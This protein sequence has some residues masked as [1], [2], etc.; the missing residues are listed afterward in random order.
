LPY[1]F[2]SF[3]GLSLFAIFYGLDWLATVP[4]T[5]RL[6]AQTFGQENT[7]IMYG[8]LGAAHQA[9]GALAAF[10]AGLLRMDL[11]TYLQA[12]MLSG[13]MCLIA[14]LMVM[15]IGFNQKEPR[16]EAITFVSSA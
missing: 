16:Q 1:S 4:P 13:L 15:F 11:G 2:V 7:G 5:V 9:G 10:L 6:A 3:Y 8:W 14:A 12:F